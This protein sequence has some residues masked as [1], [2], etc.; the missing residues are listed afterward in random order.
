MAVVITGGSGFVGQHL[1]RALQARGELVQAWS[2][3]DDAAHKFA[4]ADVVVHLAARVHVMAEASADPL[5]EFRQANVITTEW[6]A[7]TAAAAGVRRFVF[8]SS[9]KVNGEESQP[10]CAFTERDLPQPQDPYGVSKY[11]AEMAL[12]RVAQETGMSVVIIRAPL[13]YGPG[14]RAN[15][16]Q[17]MHAVRRGWPLPLGYVN[18]LRSLVGVDN[19]VD[20]VMLCMQHPAAVNETFLVSDGHDVS[21]VQLIQ[22]MATAAGV[23]A[24]VWP[25]P[26]WVLQAVARCLGK[27]AALQRLCGDLQVDIA[28][29]RTLL[30]WQPPFSV[31][32]GLQRAMAQ[33]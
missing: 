26:L 1:T 13:V 28:K 7:R 29:A 15:F 22:G 19:L 4:G 9:V 32:E 31:Q 16:A 10:G 5:R 25:I 11:E 6:L 18:N 33:G 14:V 3:G 24:R 20:F 23:P 21:T 8:M 2:R 17:L 30:N 12:H 27:G